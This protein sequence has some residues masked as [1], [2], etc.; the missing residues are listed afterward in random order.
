MTKLL[1]AVDPTA[2]IIT[3]PDPN[4]LYYCVKQRLGTIKVYGKVLTYDYGTFFYNVRCVGTDIR[5]GRVPNPADVNGWVDA[6]V[7]EFRANAKVA[8][9]GG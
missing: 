6:I 4:L 8:E 1:Y 2:R 5:A 7:A 9:K 3:G